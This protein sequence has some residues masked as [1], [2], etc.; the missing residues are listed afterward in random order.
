MTKSY[1]SLG[2]AFVASR[3]GPFK[4][5]LPALGLGIALLGGDSTPARADDPPNGLSGT[6]G[7]N[8][9]RPQVAVGTGAMTYEVPFQ[10]PP[11]RGAAQPGLSLHYTSGGGVGEAGVGWSLDLPA[12]ERAPLAGA[13]KYRDP[14]S[15]TPADEDRYTY[16]G[17]PLTFLCIVG[18][19]PCSS[20][21]EADVAGPGPAWANGYRHYRL[22]V[23]GSFERF[24]QK[25]DRK[26][27]IVQRRGGEILEFGAPLTKPN[28][29]P[30]SYDV[31][32]GTTSVFRWNLVRQRDLH[33]EFNTIIYSWAGTAP[34]RQYLRDIYYSAGG[35]GNTLD[36][37]AYHVELSWELPTFR[38]IDY[39]P[40]DRRR[41]FRRLRRVAVFEQDVAQRCEPRARSRIHHGLL[42]SSHVPRERRTGAA[43]RKVIV[44]E[45]D[46]R[47]PMPDTA[48]RGQRP[49]ARSERVPTA[50]GDDIRLR[51]H[52]ARGR[53]RDA[54]RGGLVIIP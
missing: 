35:F 9:G 6:F 28:V 13:P 54:L 3:L 17:R 30:P 41:W 50:P 46:D 12:I 24:F 42:P 36:N 33:G 18:T 52:A 49:R 38:Q 19:T 31:S 37:F 15:D 43:P 16:G 22:Q 20:A 29:S 14:A 27:W 48:C 32:A 53:R 21:A 34:E 11:A 23:E 4:R 8:A 44:E 10:L 1:D 2:V 25:P 7:E 47:R 26:T 51:A 45:R 39:T 5:L 40:V